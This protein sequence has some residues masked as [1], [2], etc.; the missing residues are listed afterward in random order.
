MKCIYILKIIFIILFII[1][2]VLH[3]Y[4]LFGNLHRR[5]YPEYYNDGYFKV[6]DINYFDVRKGNQKVINFHLR[7]G[8]KIVSENDLDFFFTFTK[9]DYNHIRSKYI[10]FLP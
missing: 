5:I 7:F 1:I 10:K 2:I 8:A 3:E 9:S 6:K 4:E